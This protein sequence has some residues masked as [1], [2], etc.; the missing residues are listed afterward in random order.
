MEI[1]KLNK[2]GQASVNGKISYL[3][4]AVIVIV[5]AVAVAPEMFDSLIQLNNTSGVPTWVPTVLFVIVG[6]GLVFLIWRSFGN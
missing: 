1:S 6:S 3:I 4:G 5:M 2:R